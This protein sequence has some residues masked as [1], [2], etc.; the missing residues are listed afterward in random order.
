LYIDH[1]FIQY[2]A[3]K[4]ITNGRVTQW[5]LLLQEFDITIKD[6]LGKENPV[7]DFLSRI[8]KVNDPLVVDDQFSNE[9]L[10]FVAVKTPWYVDVENYLAV[11]KLPKHLTTRERKLIVQHSA[12]FS[13]IGIYIFHTG[14]DMCIRRCIR[15]DEMPD[16]LKACHEKPC[17]VHFADQRTRH[18]VL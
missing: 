10:F 8:P 4:P 3:N 17:G 5:L 7:V 6:F 15:E 1:S 16:I 13:W 9:H 11:G 12:W 18:K 2:L 14:A